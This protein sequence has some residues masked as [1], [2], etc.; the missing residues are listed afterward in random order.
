MGKCHRKGGDNDI[1]SAV[2]A[3]TK[4]RQTRG[5]LGRHLCHPFI[6]IPSLTSF[7]NGCIVRWSLQSR[8]LGDTQCFDS[9]LSNAE[10]FWLL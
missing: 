8:R 7:L 4:T 5:G 6:T 1:Y 2:V 3:A 10:F 9:D